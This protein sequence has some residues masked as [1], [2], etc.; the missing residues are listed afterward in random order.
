MRDQM[1]PQDWASVLK[2]PVFWATVED[3]LEGKM[4]GRGLA[5]RKE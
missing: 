1:A 2:T 3:D 5:R 4:A